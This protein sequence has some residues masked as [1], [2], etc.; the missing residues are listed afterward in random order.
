MDDELRRRAART[1]VAVSY[2]DS[3]GQE[4]QVG[5]DAVRAVL[6]AAGRPPVPAVVARPTVGAAGL[7]TLEGGGTRAVRPGERI[8]PGVHTIE[9]A[10][11]TRAPLV[12]APAAL[13]DPLAGPGPMWGWQVQLYQLRGAGSWGIGDYRDLITLVRAAARHGADLVLVNP[14]HALTPVHPVQPSPY[15]PSSRRFRDQ[16]ALSIDLLDEYRAA[17]PAVR[18][19]VDA[20][21]PPSRELI[22]RD[23]VWRAK[24]AA[25]ELLLP[26]EVPALDDPA[27]EAELHGFA[28]FC[29][30]AEQHG[31]DWHRWPEPLRRP[32]PAAE[33]AA[34]ERRVRLHRW[35]QLAA[36]GQLDAA[37]E[38]A[39]EAGMAV[40]VVHDLAVGVGPDGADAWLLAGELADGATIGAPPDPFNQLGQGWGLPPLRPDRLAA[41]G[42]AAFR[43]LIRAALRHGGGLRID[44]VMGLFRLWWIPDGH[45]PTDGAY[46]SYDAEAMLAV[47]VLEASVSG[48]LVVGEDLGTVQPAVHEAL[49]RAGI[50]G[51]SVLW[52]END[53]DTG[54]PLPPGRWRA[55]AVASVSTHDLPTG[56]GFLAGEQVRVR[57]EL[58][59]LA[60][61][62]EQ[63][64]RAAAAQRAAL[65]TALRAEG[66]L[67]AGDEDPARAVE[68]M[69]RY[70][71]RT[72]ARIVLAAP[73][74]AVGDLRQPNLPGTVDE[75]PNWRL[76]LADGTGRQVSLEEFVERAG[77]LAGVL[78]AGAEAA[79]PAPEPRPATR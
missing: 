45:P 53:P 63:E 60:R 23:E 64:R 55:R 28:V 41:T 51:S 66:L 42:F 27:Q 38:A 50:Y 52:F 43:S 17:P 32:G 36:R 7:V 76:P 47:L 62:V 33:A 16:L 8:P 39:R 68:A 19:E 25:C 14:L 24:R 22:D 30:L 9:L 3:G 44:H 6:A 61:P 2:Q 75:Y 20:L 46:V 59:Q 65:L 74:D 70:L 78:R 10:D 54:R 71:M 56:Y 15:Y 29:A 21:R 12:A 79:R 77:R 69:Y 18:A 5:P 11:G 67:A 1:G 4:R 73:A 48:A 37:A 72:S 57:A 49:D 40:G 31:P 26:G 58:G 34:Q 13:A 35:I